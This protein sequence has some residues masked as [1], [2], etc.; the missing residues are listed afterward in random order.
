M[1]PR[2]QQKY[3]GARS[4]IP[5]A[6]NHQAALNGPWA[7]KFELIKEA[8]GV[9]VFRGL[10]RQLKACFAIAWS[11]AIHS[12]LV[13]RL[14]CFII[15]HLGVQSQAFHQAGSKGRGIQNACIN[16]SAL[17]QLIAIARLLRS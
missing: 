6:K 14:P 10:F 3:G 1:R 13:L 9:I 7:K 17:A 11:P 5:L 2:Q 15:L 4:R 8:V 12:P 16:I